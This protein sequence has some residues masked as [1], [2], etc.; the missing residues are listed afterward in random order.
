MSTLMQQQQHHGNAAARPGLHIK[1]P[2][3]CITIHCLQRTPTAES[4]RRIEC[5]CR[6]RRWASE[7]FQRTDKSCQKK[8]CHSATLLPLEL[9]MGHEQAISKLGRQQSVTEL[10]KCSTCLGFSYQTG[11][12]VISSIVHSL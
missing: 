1:Q 12:R 3:T 10:R 5:E 4:V 9:V 8:H 11:S 6:S 7:D 2:Q